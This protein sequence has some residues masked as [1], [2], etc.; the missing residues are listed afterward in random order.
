MS[1]D[2]KSKS[3]WNRRIMTFK[4]SFLLFSNCFSEGWPWFEVCHT[5]HFLHGRV[6]QDQLVLRLCTFS[7]LLI[8]LNGVILKLSASAWDGAV[9]SDTSEIKSKSLSPQTFNQLLVQE[10]QSDSTYRRYWPIFTGE[11]QGIVST[12]ALWPGIY[13]RISPQHQQKQ[14]SALC[15]RSNLGISGSLSRKA[16]DLWM[17]PS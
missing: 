8:C 11:V 12:K 9:K 1:R 2:P 17:L 5:D 16:G 13:F 4:T 3:L 10:H 6:A 15:Q 14:S 7:F